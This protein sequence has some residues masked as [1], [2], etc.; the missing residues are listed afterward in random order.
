MKHTP[1]IRA[2]LDRYLEQKGLSLAQF[3]QLAGMNRG[4]ISA[5]VSG[6]KSMSI[7]QLD[8]ITEAMCLPEGHFYDLFIENYIIDHPPNM[9]R[10]EPFLYRCAELDKLDAIRRVVGAIMDNL[11]YSPKLFE[12]AE[13]LLSQG[14]NAAALLLYEGVAE[15]EKYQHSERLAVCQYRIFTI[16]VGDDQSKNLSAATIFEVFVERLDEIDQLDALKDLANVYRSLRKWDKVDEMARQMRAKAEIQYSLKHQEKRELRDI[17]KRTR[18]PLFGYIAYADLL[19]ASVCEARGDYQQALQYTYA[20]ADLEWVK[21][22]DED[23]RHWVNLFSQWAEGN[24]YV[25]KLLSGDVGVLPDYV[26]YIAATSNAN[27]NEKLSKLL[28]IMIAANRYQI[29]V[30]DVLSR[31]E[32]D[33]HSFAKLPT[34]ADMYTQQVIPDYFAWFGFEM[35]HY[36]LHRGKYTDGFKFLMNAMVKSHII[37]NETYFINCIGLFMRFQDH[38]APAIQMEFSDLIEKVWLSNVKE[39]NT[40]NHFE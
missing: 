39:N 4:I 9:R 29:N 36:Y 24:I 10:I 27:E 13:E 35:A 34:V 12:I 2:E 23:T 15:A 33:I 21:E 26:E 28:N 6:N 25:N 14:K 20:Y 31:F 8:L 22:T 11:L 40:V 5:I 17:E 37:N 32:M 1:T 16:Q 3:G 30:D 7:N 19:Y 18:G 38:A